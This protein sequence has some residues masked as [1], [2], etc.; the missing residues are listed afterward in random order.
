LGSPELVTALHELLA[1]NRYPSEY[2]G[3]LPHFP[4]SL[5]GNNFLVDVIVVQGSFD[6]NMIFGRDYVYAMRPVVYTLF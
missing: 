4:I 3:I 6:F 2:L 1:F 5:G